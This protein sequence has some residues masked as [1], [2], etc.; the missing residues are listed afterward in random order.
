[1]NPAT[2]KTIETRRAT[3]PLRILFGSGS[4]VNG[5]RSGRFA[6]PELSVIAL[7]ETL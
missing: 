3:S 6:V 5:P 2:E 1:M 7:E 4:I